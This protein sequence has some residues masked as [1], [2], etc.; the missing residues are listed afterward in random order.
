MTST[1]LL[2]RECCALTTV[3]DHGLR[4]VG[5]YG[6]AFKPGTDDLRESPFVELA[7]RRFIKGN[8]CDTEAPEMSRDIVEVCRVRK[9]SDPTS[10]P[11]PNRPGS[12]GS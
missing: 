8:F 2:F 4:K 10:D 6:I 11:S 1:V 9:G 5:F 3:L 12:V 7:E